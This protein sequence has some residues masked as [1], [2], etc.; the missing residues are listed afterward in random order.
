MYLRA[1][2]NV[3]P[4]IVKSAISAATAPLR[5]FL[6]RINKII[7][8]L[9]RLTLARSKGGG[10]S[11][12]GGTPPGMAAGGVVSSPQLIYAGEAVS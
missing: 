12:G 4:N 3:I 5:A 9:R 2:F 6:A 7:A 11:S 10:S 1:A 8:R